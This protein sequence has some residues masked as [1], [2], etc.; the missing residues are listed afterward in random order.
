MSANI[1]SLGRFFRRFLAG[2]GL[3]APDLRRIAPAVIP[4]SKSCSARLRI[5]AN[6]IGLC[7]S[8]VVPSF[9]N[10]QIATSIDSSSAYALIRGFAMTVFVESCQGGNLFQNFV[11]ACL[12]PPA[13]V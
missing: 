4:S 6:P 3:K 11:S 9:C 2:S 13:M 1:I 12:H 8:I 7:L 5:K 10:G